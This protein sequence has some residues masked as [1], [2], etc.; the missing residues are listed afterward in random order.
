MLAYYVEWHM[1][2][3]WRRCCSTSLTRKPPKPRRK[4]VVAKAQRSQTAVTKQTTG[5]TGDGLPVHSFRTL[6]TDLAT[7]ARKSIVTAITPLFPITV[8]TELTPIQRK[9]FNLQG[10]KCSR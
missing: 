8:L 7:V 1:R 3:V 2:R 9:A 5:V 4:S 10:V 6:L